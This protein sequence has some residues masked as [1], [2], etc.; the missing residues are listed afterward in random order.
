MEAA[1]EVEANDALHSTHL[2]HIW[3]G[4]CSLI[5]F[6]ISITLAADLRAL[7]KLGRKAKEDKTQ[8]FLAPP[9]F[10]SI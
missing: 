1:T 3:T 6:E 10:A 9:V 2:G 4:Y 8:R 5:L 7:V